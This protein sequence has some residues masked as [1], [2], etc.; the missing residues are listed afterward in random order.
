M[1]LQAAVEDLQRAVHKKKSKLYPARQRFSLPL[2]PNQKLKPTALTA[3]SLLEDY[4]ITDGSVIVLKD[5]G[6][7]VIWHQLM[8]ASEW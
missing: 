7:Q 5:L 8:Q 6:P 4:G 1:T 3:G 2:P